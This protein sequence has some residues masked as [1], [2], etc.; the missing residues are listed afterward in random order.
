MLNLM[1]KLDYIDICKWMYILIGRMFYDVSDHDNWQ[2]LPYLLVLAGT[3]KS[4]ILEILNMIY[5]KEDIGYLGN[6]VEKTVSHF[7]LLKTKFIFLSSELRDW[8]NMDPGNYSTNDFWRKMFLFSKKFKQLQ[9]KVENSGIIASNKDDISRFRG[10]ISRRLFF[11][12]FCK[13]SNR[14]RS[15][16]P[17]ETQRRNSRNHHQN[18]T[19][20]ILKL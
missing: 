7:R 8:S 16:T 15:W 12:V 18:V 2:I 19:K 1:M 20:H 13:E 9:Q 6:N 4:T 3:G 17:A 5:E 10:S 11:S 14:K